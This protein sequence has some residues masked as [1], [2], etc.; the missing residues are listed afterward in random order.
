MSSRL[1]YGR[2]AVDEQDIA[3]VAEALRAEMITQG[4]RVGD[5]EEAFAGAVGASHAVA[6]SSGTAALHAAAAACE[7]G[8]GDTVLTTPISFVASSNCI[9]YTGGRVR[10]ADID[11][12]TLNLDSRKAVA[13]GATSGIKAVL[14]VSLGGLPAD[15]SS[16]QAL[17]AAG[18]RVIEDGCH[19]LGGRRGGLPVGGD[20]PADL[21]VFSLHP[22]KAITSGEGGI[23][24]THDQD[25]ATRLR[26]FR[27]HGI[28]REHPQHDPASG[29]DC[30]VLRGPWHYDV[31]SLGFNYRITD[32]Q[33]ALGQ[34]QLGK[35]NGFIAAR[36]AIAARYRELLL[37]VHHLTLPP[38]APDGSLHAYHLFIVR[39]DE[40]AVRRRIVCEGLL[41]EGISTQLHYIPIYRHTLYRSLG[42]GDCARAL[43][44]A[45]GYYRS[46]LSLPIFPAMSAGDVRRVVDTL[47]RLMEASLDEP[48][49]ASGTRYVAAAT[50]GS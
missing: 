7:L 37:D 44:H 10:F 28:V 12:Q 49:R 11:P 42:Y 4:P 13:S 16:L 6:F 29:D 18:V 47:K 8:K 19:A 50:Q 36:N 39:F 46:A 43:P 31:K 2:Q 34:S 9:L 30:E 35:L 27:S 17:R 45:E 1:P 23:V 5:F 3:Q 14:A 21:S 38:E 40:G 24:T 48:K 41:A 20:G 15:L 26:A 32:F 25:L 22:L 33:C